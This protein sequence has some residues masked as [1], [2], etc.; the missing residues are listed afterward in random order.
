MGNPVSKRSPSKMHVLKASRFNDREPSPLCT[1][2][3]EAENNPQ[4]VKKAAGAG[5]RRICREARQ[6]N[7]YPLPTQ[8]TL[9]GEKEV[10]QPFRRAKS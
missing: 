1:S 5:K 10:G 4:S 6:C 8:R 7:R 3:H 9:C 2:P